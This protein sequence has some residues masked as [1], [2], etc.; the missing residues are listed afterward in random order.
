[1]ALLINVLFSISD[2]ARDV[3]M[4]SDQRDRGH[5]SDEFRERHDAR[6][7]LHRRKTREYRSTTRNE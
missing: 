3:T 6:I 4:A 1:M 2:E 5:E 7:G